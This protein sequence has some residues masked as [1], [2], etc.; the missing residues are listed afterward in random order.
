MFVYMQRGVLSILCCLSSTFSLPPYSM[1]RTYIGE[2]HEWVEEKHNGYTEARV[3][4]GALKCDKASFCH[5]GPFVGTPV[6]AFLLE[7]VLTLRKNV[8]AVVSYDW[9]HQEKCQHHTVGVGQ[10]MSSK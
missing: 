8:Y 6:E 3:A 5:R 4:R 1:Q 10:N 2:K 9:K 7:R